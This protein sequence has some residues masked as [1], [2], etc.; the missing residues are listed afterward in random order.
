MKRLTLESELLREQLRLARIAKYGSASE[1]LN[2][3]QLSL[4]ED[5]PGVSREEVLAETARG[6]LPEAPPNKLRSFLVLLL[7]H[8]PEGKSAPARPTRIHELSIR[9]RRTSSKRLLNVFTIPRPQRL[10]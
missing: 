6:A 7:P 5:E 3:A 9:F 2:D 10:D 1:K 4:L 8:K